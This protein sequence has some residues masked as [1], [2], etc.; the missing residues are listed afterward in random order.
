MIETNAARARRLR[1]SAA[2]QQRHGGRHGHGAGKATALVHVGSTAFLGVQVAS[3]VGSG[4]FGG[5]T[6][7]GALIA[8]TITGGSAASAGLPP[9]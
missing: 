9:Q 8:G 1:R 7:G 3:A 2:E 4:G 5:P 6:S